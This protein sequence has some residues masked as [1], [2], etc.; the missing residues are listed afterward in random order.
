[1]AITYAKVMESRH[2]EE[3]WCQDETVLI[4]LEWIVRDVAHSGGKCKFSHYIL[5]ILKEMEKRLEKLLW[6][7]MRRV[8][9]SFRVLL[10][11]LWGCFN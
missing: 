8:Y 10:L 3:I 11:F 6:I 5:L 1:M 9:L 7:G 2:I 4:L